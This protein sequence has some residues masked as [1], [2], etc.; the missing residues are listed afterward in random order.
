MSN[1]KELLLLHMAHTKQALNRA[2]NNSYSD[3]RKEEYQN[4][5]FQ[6]Y[7]GIENDVNNKLPTLTDLQIYNGPKKHLTF[8][9]K[10]LEFLDS[11][12]LNQIP[13]EIVACLN[14]AMNDWEPSN[15]FIIVTSLINDVAGF[16]FDGWIAFNDSLYNDIKVRYSIDFNNKLVQINLPRTFARD[17]LANVVLYHE[18]GHFIDK[19]YQLMAALI[20]DLHDKIYQNNFTTSELIEIEAFLPTLKKFIASSPKVPAVSLANQGN[21]NIAL[22]H[23]REYFC[24]LFAAQYIGQFSSLYVTYL[25]DNNPKIS[26]SHPATTL[27]T[28]VVNDYISGK[29]NLI[30]DLINAA[31]YKVF[32]TE[33]KKRYAE[34]QPGDFYSLIPTTLNNHQEL[35]GIF[36]TAW[37]IWLEKQSDI[38][39]G[40][41]HNNDPSKIYNVIN[42]LV[43][44][45][46]GNYI[47]VNQWEKVTKI[48][49]LSVIPKQWDPSKWKQNSVK[50]IGTLSKSRI[51]DLLNSRKLFIRPLLSSTQIGEIG[52]DFRLGYDFLV[53]IQGREAFINASKN[54]WLA[55]EQQRNVSQFFQSSRR[56]LGETFILHPRQTVL[57]VTLEYVKLPDD[58]MLMLFMRSSYSRLGMTV[59]TIVQPGYCGCLS[60]EFTN[61]N[62]NPINL[63]VGS[64]IVQGVLVRVSDTTNYFHT[65]RKY[66]CQVRPE[67]SNVA[68]DEDLSYLNNLWKLNNERGTT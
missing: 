17:Y 9:L 32:A 30:I 12:T 25:S 19:Q 54:T 51:I 45:S 14:H 11:S 44:K 37:H 8:I 35:H 56:Q 3:L 41:N 59:S 6:L 28:K 27:R 52:I 55:N 38:A 23:L 10:S 24:D 18:L 21:L 42:N 1:T 62:N 43:E 46:I 20:N 33:L 49:P 4:Q 58:C 16:S 48:E 63:S 40:I 47:A 31:V 61:N 2:K 26:T 34:V 66:S 68:N 36:S 7:D 64:R 50:P 13:Y 39:K 5:L 57:A 15:K 65:A 67:S 60:L 53:S 22:S 29:K